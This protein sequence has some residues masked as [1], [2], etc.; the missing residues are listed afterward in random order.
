[1]LFGSGGLVGYDDCLTRSR[2]P[3]RSRA[4]VYSFL[5]LMPGGDCRANQIVSNRR[6]PPLRRI[7]SSPM[8]RRANGLEV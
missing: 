6:G 4:G 2:S 1:M 5:V 8:Q 7:G 3:V